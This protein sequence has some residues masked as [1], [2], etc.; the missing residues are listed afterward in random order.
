M[1]ISRKIVITER[2]NLGSV[3]GTRL[4]IRNVFQVGPTTSSVGITT[5]SSLQQSQARSLT[6]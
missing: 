5:V 6:K 1:S 2:E 4:P 3:V